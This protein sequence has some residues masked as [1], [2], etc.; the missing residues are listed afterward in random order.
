MVFKEVKDKINRYYKEI[1]GFIVARFAV[2]QLPGE[3]QHFG[4][5]MPMRDI[6]TGIETDTLGRPFNLKNIHVVDT[7][8]LPDI[9]GTP[10]TLLVMANASRI[11]E[12]GL[13]G[14]IK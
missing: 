3:S 12:Q 9:P 2:K 4:A 1:G 8:I 11:V 7:S 14:T 13:K 10:T 5:S 6:P